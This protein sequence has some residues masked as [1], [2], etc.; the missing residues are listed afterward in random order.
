VPQ[1]SHKVTDH[2]VQAPGIATGRLRPEEERGKETAKPLPFFAFPAGVK[3]ERNQ[4][5][6]KGG[7]HSRARVYVCVA[8]SWGL[9]VMEKEHVWLP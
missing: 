2:V 7:A 5:V 8:A 4:E 6:G 1:P 3:R 9:A